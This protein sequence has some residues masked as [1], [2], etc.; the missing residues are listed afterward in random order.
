MQQ[1]SLYRF[2]GYE[3]LSAIRNEA[4]EVSSPVKRPLTSPSEKE[5]N[6][7]VK[8]VPFVPVANIFQETVDESTGKRTREHI[9]TTYHGE[10]TYVNALNGTILVATDELVSSSP[11]KVYSGFRV[12][13]SNVSMLIFCQE[14][15]LTNDRRVDSH[16]VCC[17]LG[18]SG[19]EDNEGG[20]CTGE[21]FTRVFQ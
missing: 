17:G 21:A 10:E 7:R 6:I 9:T 2:G 19:R 14:N 12:E 4:S 16:L 5:N 3:P 15:A 8:I 11:R 18:Q 1:Q 20:F 13:Y